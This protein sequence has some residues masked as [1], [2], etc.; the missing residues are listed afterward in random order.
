MATIETAIR[1]Y[2]GMTPALRGIT[3]ALNIVLSGFQSV[4]NASHNI[5]DTSCIVS[6]RA[7]LNK[8][9]MAI[10][11]IEGAINSSAEAQQK[12]NNKFSEGAKQ[13]TGLSSKFKQF[14]AAYGG[15][16]AVQGVLNVSDQLSQTSARLNLMNDG[17]QSTSELQNMIFQSAQNSRSNY[18]DTAAF[19]S[20]LG[21]RSGNAF[22]DNKETVAFANQLNKQ[23]VIAGASQDEVRS[24]TLQLTQAL[25]SGVLRG[26]EFNAVFEAAPN[27]M[28]T[29]ADYMDVPLGSLREMAADG[30]ISADIVKNAM[31]SAADETNARFES[32]P[33][34]FGQVWTTIKNSAIQTFQPVLQ[35]IGKLTGSDE[36]QKVI[37]GVTS[38]I[39]VAATVAGALLGIVVA[40]GSFVV[41][42][43]SWISPII[44]GIAAALAVYYGWVLITNAAELIS[45]GI[46]IA[47][48]LASYARATILKK[49]AS[50]TAVATA[51]QY[52]FNT[53]LLASPITWIIMAI[54]AVIAAI[55]VVV[56]II[57]KCAG[58]TIS[59]TGVIC[60]A[61]MWLLALIAN[62]V[63]GLANGLVQI[64][65]SLFVEP[66]LGIFEWI[67]NAANGGFNSF[68]GAVA[69]LIGQIIS[70]FLSLGKVVTQIIDAIFGSDWTGGLEKLQGQVTSWGK[71][72]NHLT[73]DRSAPTIDYRFGMINAYKTG[74]SFGKGIDNKIS[75]FF[76]KNKKNPGDDTFK[77]LLEGTYN[78][79]N[80]NNIAND[81]SSISDSMDI[82]E[83]DLQYMRDLAEQEAINRFTTAD[84]RVEFT[85]NNSI[86]SNLDIDGVCDYM[87]NRTA[88]QL[89]L[90]AEGVH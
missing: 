43:W 31:L 25:G 55:Y 27:I 77:D 6:A 66:F 65:W 1:I 20:Q 50:A 28:Q 39:A 56:A 36:F 64:L 23:F 69:N 26:E 61:V 78:N 17:K 72:E 52:G 59:A 62:A 9:E 11:D 71:S 84:L 88:E 47:S 30:Q 44:Y 29:L 2:D 80:L 46:K 58:T 68:G 51:A 86:N 49:E 83:E 38:A 22:K 74:D 89:A 60:G 53:A 32:M 4:E 67:L 24:A 54:I 48:C 5:I 13:S 19:V 82:A 3:N 85:A 18:M 7:E 41:D 8:A 57:N 37:Q 76:D 10:N 40:I 79:D 90:V 81:T 75:G 87:A 16:K 70:W 63:I 34:T 73:I 35:E 42:N 21:I 14:A 15:I 45:A 33:M 12:L